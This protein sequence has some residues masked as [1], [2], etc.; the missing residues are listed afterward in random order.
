MNKRIKSNRGFLGPTHAL[1]AVSLFLL[2]TWLAKD[3]VFGTML[4]TTNITVYITSLIIVVGAALMPDL[5]SVRSTSIS[6][7]GIVGKVLSKAMRATSLL[8]QSTIKGKY[9]KPTGDPHRGF[10]H[11]AISAVLAGLLVSLVTSITIILPFKLLGKSLTIGMLFTSLI[12]FISIQL[13]FASLFGKHYSKVKRDGILSQIGLMIVS[14]VIA[15]AITFALPDNINYAWVGFSFGLGWLLHIF[16]DMFTVAGVPV[17]FPY[18]RKGKRWW[19][20]RMPFAIKAGGP[21]EFGLMVP[22][23]TIIGIIS[24]IQIIPMFLK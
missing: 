13:A 17:L 9:D 18:A 7:L 16:G 23:F 22:L 14:G 11:T 5:D 20:Y 2:I 24:F 1:S 15:L 6:T 19:T 10:W 4:N 3:F 12:I 21:I 8:I